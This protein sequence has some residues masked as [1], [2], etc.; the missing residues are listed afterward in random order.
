VKARLEDAEGSDG[1]GDG[2]APMGDRR[3]Y[4]VVATCL[5]G[6]NKPKEGTQWFGLA[7]GGVIANSSVEKHL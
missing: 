6:E 7:T 5:E 2:I 3:R 4:D 1:T